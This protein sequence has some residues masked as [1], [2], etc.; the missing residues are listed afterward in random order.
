M[1][2]FLKRLFGR[3]SV[4]PPSG[5]SADWFNPLLLGV[6]A[7]TEGNPRETVEYRIDRTVRMALFGGLLAREGRY[8]FVERDVVQ[9][10]GR[11]SLAPMR[12]RCWGP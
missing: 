8:Q 6:W 10:T 12:R 5:G 3:C 7:P 2:K 1:L 4:I 11:T 9:M